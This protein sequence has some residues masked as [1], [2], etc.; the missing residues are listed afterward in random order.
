M[1]AAARRWQ[2]RFMRQCCRAVPPTQSALLVISQRM[3]SQPLFGGGI[4]ISAVESDVAD[5]F[6][7]SLRSAR[8]Q[9]PIE[10]QEERTALFFLDDL[11]QKQVFSGSRHNGAHHRSGCFED[12]PGHARSYLMV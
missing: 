8:Q 11:T 10:L 1:Q 4:D 3:E 6:G 5:L 9:K 7:F 2:T 12:R